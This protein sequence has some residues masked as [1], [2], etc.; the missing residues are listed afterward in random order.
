LTLTKVNL[1]E[2][3]AKQRLR[4]LVHVVVAQN[5]FSR[6]VAQ[7]RGSDVVT[8]KTRLKKSEQRLQHELVE[9]GFGLKE[10]H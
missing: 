8:D 2:Y 1:K 5:K 3:L 6:M 7:F 10:T 4:K 9:F